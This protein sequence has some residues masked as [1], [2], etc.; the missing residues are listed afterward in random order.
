MC[1]TCGCKSAET[2]GAERQVYVLRFSDPMRYGQAVE[3]PFLTKNEAERYVDMHIRT[4]M[5]MWK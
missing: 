5:I 3:L 1:N 2:F 4:Y